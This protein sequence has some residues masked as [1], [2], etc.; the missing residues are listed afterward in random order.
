M[1]IGT[2]AT[3]VPLVAVIVLFVVVVVV[4]VVLVALV[5]SLRRA[6]ARRDC[7]ASGGA[8][9]LP[10][11]EFSGSTP[12]SFN[13]RANAA[14]VAIDDAVKTSEQ[15]LGFAEAQFGLEATATFG[16]ALEAAS[17]V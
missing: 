10:T 16:T 5:L 7:A 2:G 9:G 15:E 1:N 6:V 11:D 12:A 8:A 4:V 17:G 13:A 14:L 3:S